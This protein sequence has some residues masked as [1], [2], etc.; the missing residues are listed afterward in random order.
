ME[1]VMTRQNPVFKTAA[2]YPKGMTPTQ[3]IQRFYQAII[4]KDA[5]RIAR[6]YV[7]DE[8]T[9]VVLEGPRQATKGFSKIQKGWRDFCDS[10]LTLNAIEWIEGPLE[11]ASGDMAWM[12]GIVQLTI[13]LRGR[14]FSRK[15]RSSFV[16]RRNEVDN[17]WRIQHE[18]V[19][20]AMPD[21]YGIGDWLKK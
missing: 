11:E 20:A 21:P 8:K 12:A 15:F 2:I 10:P 9:Y 5:E 13:S 1:K 4:E 14:N 18:H 6:F 17:F 19:S 7:P 16:M 3:T